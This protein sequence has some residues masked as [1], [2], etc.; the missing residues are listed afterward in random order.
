MALSLTHLCIILLQS[1]SER[2]VCYLVGSSHLI[3]ISRIGLHACLKQ[4]T[5]FLDPGLQLVLPRLVGRKK[6][7]QL[8]LAL[9]DEFLLASELLIAQLRPLVA[10][11]FYFVLA[12]FPKVFAVA[13]ELVQLTLLL[14][15][16]LI[17]FSDSLG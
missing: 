5:E 3:L 4:I 15:L 6:P 9:L 10:Q 13:V 1:V 2:V 11:F 17:K 12:C 7:V 16:L 8:L 14:L